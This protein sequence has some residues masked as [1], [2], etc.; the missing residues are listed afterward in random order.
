MTQNKLDSELTAPNLS[1]TR[2]RALGGHWRRYER[3]LFVGEQRGNGERMDRDITG[4]F[5]EHIF[6]SYITEE[7]D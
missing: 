6:Q 5:R 7:S 3:E 2:M 1:G 4:A